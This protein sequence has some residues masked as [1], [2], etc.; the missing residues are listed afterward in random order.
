MPVV[1][2][3]FPPN[4]DNDQAARSEPRRRRVDSKVYV[5]TCHLGQG[6]FARERIRAGEI[7]FVL[8]GTIISYEEAVAKGD[9]QGNPIQIDVDRYIDV[10]APGV[11]LN[12]SCDPNAGIKHGNLL[13]ALRTIQP[14][15][16]IA[17]DYSTTMSEDYWTMECQCGASQC[18]RV[19]TDFY[20]LPHA[21][22]ERYITLGIVQ[23]FILQ[24]E[25][26]TKRGQPVWRP[27][28][29]FT[30]ARSTILLPHAMRRS[31]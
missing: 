4:G 13:V 8:A 5:G 7:I 6:V 15:E 3:E 2:D 19:I 20:L 27:G 22:K 26:A 14:G 9:T 1:K 23:E 25:E 12:H 30:P 10:I 18:R 24:Q 11:F 31:A 17:F 29:R 28:Q 21:L 16:H